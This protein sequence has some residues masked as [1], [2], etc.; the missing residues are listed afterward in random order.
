MPELVVF[1][2]EKEEYGT[3]IQQVKE[4][5]QM[6]EVTPV[7]RSPDFVMGVINLRG[8]VI[9]IIDLRVMLGL[10][11][12]EQDKAT[13]VI[14]VDVGESAIGT[15][16]DS[17][18][19]VLTLEEIEPPHPVMEQPWVTGVGKLDE[20]LIVVLDFEVLFKELVMGEITP[21]GG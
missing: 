17:V 7:P 8:K 9:P 2:L 20:R 1:K 12:K 21:S 6:T 4:I 13:R 16:V 14:V 19:E 11:P 5:R 18:A 3:E 10:P 15:V